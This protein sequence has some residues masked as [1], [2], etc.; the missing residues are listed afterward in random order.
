MTGRRS[1]GA[2][3][4]A[5]TALTV[6]T[7]TAVA[8]P[9][10]GIH[11]VATDAAAPRGASQQEKADAAKELGISPGPELMVL[12]DR[13]LVFAMWER[14]SGPLLKAAARAAYEGSPAA[15]KGFIETGIVEARQ[16]DQQAKLDAD[17]QTGAEEKAR[18]AQRDARTVAA[19]RLG[20]VM[21]E[22]LQ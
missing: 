4:I 6:L 5:A 13:N 10:A 18:L 22:S 19:A 21:T 3:L 7:G 2:A 8:A 17:T 12:S 15:Q 14:A 11:P 1:I 20:I 16:A 9:A